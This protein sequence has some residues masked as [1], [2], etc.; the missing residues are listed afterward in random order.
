MTKILIKNKKVKENWKRN[1]LTFFPKEKKGLMDDFTD[2][3]SFVLIISMV[4]FIAVVVLRTDAS[5][6][7]EQTL[8]RI[9]SFQGQEALLDLVNSLALLEDKEVVMKDVIISAVN[10]NNE[11]LFREKMQAYFEQQQMEGGVGVYDSVSYG[12]E[13]EPTPLLSYDVVVFN[14]EV[15]ARGKEKGAIYL[16]NVHGEGNKKL[17]VVKLFS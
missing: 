10:A 17:L 2:L 1:F 5:D 4:G 15:I 12:T 13:E 16:T 9:A 11:A 7:T 3:L 14:G 8:E 6:K